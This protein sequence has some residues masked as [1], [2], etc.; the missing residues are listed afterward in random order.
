M[1]KMGRMESKNVGKSTNNYYWTQIG[2]T[3]GGGNLLPF[4]VGCHAPGNL[5]D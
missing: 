5:F 1:V 3:S 2:I 4:A